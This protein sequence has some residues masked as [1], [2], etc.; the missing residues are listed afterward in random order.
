MD[1]MNNNRELMESWISDHTEYLSIV[2]DREIRCNIC[3]K[4]VKCEQKWHVTQHINTAK[5]KQNVSPDRFYEDLCEAFVA[6]N[7]PLNKLRNPKLKTFLETYTN[8]HIPDPSTIRRQYLTKC[9][10]NVIQQIK[11]NISNQYVWIS[12]DETVDITGRCVT[13]V[14]V[15]ILHPNTPSTPHLIAS[16]ITHQVNA[17]TIRDII[18]E[19][20]QNIL[21]FDQNQTHRVLLFVSDAAAYMLKAGKLLKNIYPNMLHITCVA[22]ALHRICE[23][24]RN[25]FPEVDKVIAFFK[26]I[27]R[28]AP[29]R[30]SL[31][32]EQY[33][34]L[35]LPPVP[36]LTRWGSWIEACIFYS[37]NFQSLK[38]FVFLLP[39]DARSI[40]QCKELL[41]NS[42]LETQLNFININFKH[43]IDTITYF[44]QRNIQ[45]C[46]AITSLNAII[47]NLCSIEGNFGHRL[48]EKV[49]KVFER[50]PDLVILRQFY[51]GTILDRN[52]FE[53]YNLLLP[54][55]NYAPVTSCDVERS[56]SIFK[57]ILTSKRTSF[58]DE[59][60]EQTLI[61]NTNCTLFSEI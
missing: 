15:G 32:K 4:T 21:Q 35:P 30:V 23:F 20:L 18:N 37:K 61:I 40:E 45:L 7:I 5:H 14:I 44:E 24:I 53:K 39:N 9:Y 38:N 22:H 60:L 58:T 48:K 6:S 12:A 55:F 52:L 31:Y 13:N 43:L 34:T 59:H 16:K 36:V 11:L 27:L 2:S 28:K 19:S 33:P 49:C 47:S 10:T 26:Q 3:S 1:S 41:Q 17:E 57:E 50:N 51:E 42:T 54:H 25:E 8:K 46:D 56:F 29:S